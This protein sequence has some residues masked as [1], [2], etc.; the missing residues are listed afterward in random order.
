MSLLDVF[1]I[2]VII[3]LVPTA[4]LSLAV[5]FVSFQAMWEDHKR[6]KDM[7]KRREAWRKDRK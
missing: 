2:I 5:V 1:V 3:I 4:V 6:E 7:K